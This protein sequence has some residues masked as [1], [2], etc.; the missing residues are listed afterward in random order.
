MVREVFRAGAYTGLKGQ[1]EFLQTEEKVREFISWE[2][3]RVSVMA[4][5][6][7]H[8]GTRSAQAKRPDWEVGGW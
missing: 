4:A 5:A 8:L 3:R 7:R 2:Y 1:R 6:Q